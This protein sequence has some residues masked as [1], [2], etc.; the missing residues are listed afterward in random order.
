MCIQDPGYIQL[1]VQN[2]LCEKLVLSHM[3]DQ[4]VQYEM[5]KHSVAHLIPLSL[6]SLQDEIVPLSLQSNP[7]ENNDVPFASGL[8]EASPSCRPTCLGTR[9]RRRCTPCRSASRSPTKTGNFLSSLL[10][11]CAVASRWFCPPLQ[12]RRCSSRSA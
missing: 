9:A 1:V 8:H 2:S 12:V 3:P 7:C 10:L 6:Q 11:C 4:S 5:K